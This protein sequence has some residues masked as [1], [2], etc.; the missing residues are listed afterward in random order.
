MAI[1]LGGGTITPAPVKQTLSTNY[2]DFTAAGTAGWAQQYLP[3]LYEA[4][5]E[6]FGDRTVGGFLK[7]VGAEM[8]MSSD[9]V[10]W[11]EQGRLHLSYSGG[12]MGADTAKANT[13]TG[14]T[15]HAI[16]VGQTVVISDGTATVK[17]YVSQVPDA[18]SIK[19]NCY[20]SDT[21][22]VAAGI[23]TTASAIKLFVYGSEFAKGTDSMNEAVTPSF[24][25]YTNNP[26]ILKDK[27]EISGSDASQIGWVEVTGES[28]ES[29]YLWYI[30]AEGETRSRFEDY[31]EMALVE[32]EKN[33]N[34]S[35]STIAGSEGYLLL[36]QA[37]VIFMK[38][39]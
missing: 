9:Q 10:I 35:T 39:D 30:K 32:A 6:K 16:R 38:T 24:Q 29:G 18:N 14:L 19:V 36:L 34:T 26:I 7:M 8:P 11:S 15:G 22:C 17:A 13:I 27:Y 25:S 23:A 12:T 2:V 37:E 20:T 33:I 4:E 5:V 31:T 21:G 3:D 28:G 1:T